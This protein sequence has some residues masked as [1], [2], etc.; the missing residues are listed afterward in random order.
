MY[1]AVRFGARRAGHSGVGGNT[2]VRCTKGHLFT[3]IWAPGISFKSIRLGMT[4]LQHRPV[5]HHWAIVTPVKESELTGEERQIASGH[6][7]IR[8]P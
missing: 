3:T 4:R 7:D 5:G 1:V 8:M 2:I 6:H